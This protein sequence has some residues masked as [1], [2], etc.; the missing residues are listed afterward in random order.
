MN[1]IFKQIRNNLDNAGK[2]TFKHILRE[3]NKTTNHYDNKAIN[4][5]E[6]DIKENEEFYHNSIP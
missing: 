5:R 1:K 2:V 6:G 4:R 3:H